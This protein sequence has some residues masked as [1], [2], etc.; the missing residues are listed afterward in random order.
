MRLTFSVLNPLD[1][2]LSN[3]V[4][5]QDII[6]LPLQNSVIMYIML[7]DSYTELRSRLKHSPARRDVYCLPR[8]E[9]LKLLIAEPTTKMGGRSNSSG[10][11]ELP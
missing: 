2:N 9:P 8:I 5:T 1:F 10:L 7:G 6:I 3:A 4:L 11:L